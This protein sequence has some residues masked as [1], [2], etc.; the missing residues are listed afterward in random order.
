MASL[1]NW[2]TAAAAFATAL[3]AKPDDGPALSELSFA[4]LSLKRLDDAEAHA[5]RAVEQSGPGSLKAASLYNLGR[6]AE[7][8]SDSGENDAKAALYYRQSLKL[9]RS[10]EVLSRLFQLDENEPE[11]PCSEP[12]PFKDLTACLRR[13]L[14]HDD[15]GV[16]DGGIA[17]GVRWLK[18]SWIP[19][20]RE[21]FG[22]ASV[23]LAARG[24]SGWQV[25]YNLG[26][27]R[28]GGGHTFGISF[29]KGVW[30]WAAGA[31]FL[32]LD[33][34]HYD[35]VRAHRMTGESIEGLNEEL[36]Y[37]EEAEEKHR[38][39]FAPSA[40][41]LPKL[42]TDAQIGC[43]RYLVLSD[44][45]VFKNLSAP[46]R[47][48]VNKKLRAARYSRNA[49]ATFGADGKL[50]GTELRGGDLERCGQVAV[51]Q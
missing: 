11:L 1:G 32:Q 6:T 27:V 18:V 42:Q 50:K 25:F 17:E 48:R 7:A 33:Y 29:G 31:K 28:D 3:R 30:L 14:V 22:Q 38:I 15:D 21:H 44:P 24:A 20:N 12:R 35:N 5:K 37:S 45:E 40:S 46:V 34:T 47:D 51:L 19:K 36:W 39:L 49:E 9:R 4:E 23:F 2:E 41:G 26:R 8:R 10:E 13:V 16:S 43:S